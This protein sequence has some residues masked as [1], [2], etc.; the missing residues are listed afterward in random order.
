MVLGSS[1]RC[2]GGSAP[3]TSDRTG[4]DRSHAPQVCCPAARGLEDQ[5]RQMERSAE[6]ARFDLD[7]PVL[8]QQLYAAAPRHG[9]QLVISDVTTDP[10]FGPHREIAAASGF[11]AVQSTPLID[12]AGRLVGV[13]H[14]LSASS[15]SLGSG[16]ADHQALCRSRQPGPGSQGRHR[17]HGSIPPPRAVR[18]LNQH[19]TPC[20]PVT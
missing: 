2:P 18:C 20:Q 4:T 6:W 14:P 12:E 9:A 19:A 5:A 13:D 3:A 1:M 11:R 8:S 10:G 16:P 15:R 7:E 17:I